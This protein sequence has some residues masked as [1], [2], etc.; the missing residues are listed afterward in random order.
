MDRKIKKK[1]SALDPRFRKKIEELFESMSESV[2]MLYEVATHDEKTGLYNNKFF[3]TLL[4]MEIEKAKRGQ[5]KLSMIIIDI[6]FFKK[7]N[8]KYGHMKADELLKKLADVIRKNVRK[9]DIAARFGGE[10]FII[11][12]PETDLE[13]AKSFSLKLRRLVH[14]DKTLKKHKLTVSGGVTQFRTKEDSK[15]KFKERVDK[16]L[17]NAKSIG[18]DKFVAVK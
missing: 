14:A 16:A 9:S 11:L 5:Q 17:Y 12:L 7:V 15:K 10:E 1:L 13:K 8:D 4:D 6:D 18:R 2:S 3:E